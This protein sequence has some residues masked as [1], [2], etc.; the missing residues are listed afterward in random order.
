MELLPPEFGP[1]I[2]VIFDIGT[3][4]ASAPKALKFLRRN[5]VNISLFLT[6]TP[7]A[8]V[9]DWGKLSFS[10][11]LR[12]PVS[13]LLCPSSEFAILSAIVIEDGNQH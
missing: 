11:R 10:S 2:S 7:L 5:S 8:A 6:C 3:F 12:Q 1:Y 13:D 4:C 9:Y